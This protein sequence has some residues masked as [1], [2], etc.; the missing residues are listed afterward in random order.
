MSK[1]HVRFILEA[2]FESPEQKTKF[3]TLYGDKFFALIKEVKSKKYFSFDYKY[4][5]SIRKML[6]QH[7]N[8]ESVIPEIKNSLPEENLIKLLEV[9]PLF[10]VSPIDLQ[11][12]ILLGLGLRE[13]KP[14]QN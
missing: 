9:V 13:I 6:R 12:F 4:L 10:G 5:P 11:A 1:L 3:L 7:N 14:A 8:L 2:T